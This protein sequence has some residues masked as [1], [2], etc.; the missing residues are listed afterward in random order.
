MSKFFIKTEEI[1]KL[2]AEYLIENNIPFHEDQLIK[3]NVLFK[4]M[5]KNP[6]N[7]E[8]IV[9][10]VS[11][12]SG[13]GKSSTAKLLVHVFDINGLNSLVVSGDNYPRRIPNYND[14][15][16]LNVFRKSALLNMVSS[17][18]YKNDYY[19]IIKKIQLEK[20]D[21]NP[22]YLAEYDWYKCYLDGGKQGLES[23]L[24]T[25]KEQDFGEVNDLLDK[26]TKGLNNL[27]LK[28]MGNDESS[29]YYEE[30]DV[31][32]TDIL[33][34]EWTHSNSDELKNVDVRLYLDSSYEKTEQR[35]KERNRRAEELDNHFI[36][37]VL[38]AEQKLLYS[39]VRNANII[40][41]F[42]G[43]IITREEF[44]KRLEE[45]I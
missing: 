32:N 41:T 30:V 31:S 5:F 26:F 24:G 40:M 20:D 11:G 29:I 43:D 16:R 3:I 19:S 15:E 12:G 44:E 13:S 36:N 45:K 23:Y 34:L 8:K 4:E 1:K 22:K 10:S 14:A 38:E 18:V 25:K 39:Q 35:R 33:I 37:A 9:V 28:H 42:E 2:T 21:A 17:G 6:V 7:K 27:Y